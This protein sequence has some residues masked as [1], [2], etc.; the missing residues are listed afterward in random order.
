MELITNLLVQ[1]LWRCR[2]V[3]W[4]FLG[5]S[6]ASRGILLMWN[7]RVVEKLEGAVRYFSVSYKFKNVEDHHMWMFSGVYGLNIDRDRRLMWDELAGIRSWWDVPWCLG[8]DFNVVRFPLERVGSSNFSPSMHDFSDFISSNELIDIPLTG[9]DFTWSNNREVS[10][11][12]RIDRFLYSADWVEDYINILQKRLDRLNSDH[13][14]VALES[15]N[16]QRRRRPFRFENM[17][18]MEE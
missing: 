13:F 6:G 1:S 12:S 15:G 9:G 2:F 8:G 17:W 5:S 3:D 7:S 11:L 10:S 16:I 14:P 18:L 4:M